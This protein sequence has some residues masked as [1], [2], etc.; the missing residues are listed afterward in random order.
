[1]A[2]CCTPPSWCA[3]TP[4]P[5]VAASPQPPHQHLLEGLTPKACLRNHLGGH[6]RCGPG[7]DQRRSVNLMVARRTFLTMTAALPAAG[8]VGAVASDA[9]EAPLDDDPDLPGYLRH[10][11]R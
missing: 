2:S 8:A 10:G 1:F 9:P 11:G 4:P 6:H 5:R 3:D 7:F